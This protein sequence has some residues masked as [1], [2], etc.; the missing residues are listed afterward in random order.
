MTFL[1]SRFFEKCL[2]P[3]LVFQGV[4]IGA[5]YGTGREIVEFFLRH[6][7]LAGLLGLI[8]ITTPIWSILL[9]ISF[10]FSRS[11]EVF[12]YRSFTQRLLGRFW[13]AFEILYVILM[14]VVLAVIASAAGVLLRDNFGIPYL[15]GVCLMLVTIGFLAYKGSMV[16]E[17]FLSS[18]SILLYVVYGS[19]LVA[20]FWKF[21]RAIAGNFAHAAP[22]AQ[23][24]LSGFKYALYNL[25]VIPALLFLARHMESRKEAVK[26]GLLGGF[27]GG[28]PAILFL[29]CLSSHYP[30][31]LT[32]EIPAVFV[33]KKLNLPLLTI[34]FQIVLFGTLIQTGIGFLHGFNE[35]VYAQMARSGKN[36]NP[37]L[38]PV[39]SWLLLLIGL[40]LAPL[41]IINLIAKGYGSL[42]WGVFLLL[43]IPLLVWGGQKISRR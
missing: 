22:F 13:W 17:S 8:L 28:L 11:F 38:R 4:V 36:L 1:K 15:A 39:I 43:F 35:R 27:I 34:A 30:S 12:D 6:G 9:A 2:K 26:A 21:G 5:G 31:V 29:F 3:G 10:E 19:F 40:G 24:S 7:P 41:G 16:I 23:W 14:L 33:L 42:S 18:W 32:A 37:K 25:I 20:S